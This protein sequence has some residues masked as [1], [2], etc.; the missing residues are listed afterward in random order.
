LLD[1]ALAIADKDMA[2]KQWVAGDSFSMADCAA[3]PPLFY[4][5]LRIA[6]LAG[7]FHNLA[8]Y[9]DRMR[10]RPSYARVLKEAEPFLHMVPA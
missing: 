2:G 8:T 3:G 6:P 9:L 1:A 10:Q 4:A 5:N 7:R